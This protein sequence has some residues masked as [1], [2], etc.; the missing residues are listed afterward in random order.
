MAD[1]KKL[2][3][4]K[5][6]RLEATSSCQLRCPS[7]PTA[8]GAIRPV[9]GKGY[10]KLGDFQKLLDE[11]PWISKIELSNYGEMFLNPDLLGIMEYA[12]RRNVI[13]T[14][15]NGVNLNTVKEDVLKGLVKYEFRSLTCSIDGASS[16]T[17][18]VYRVGGDFDKVLEHIKKI[19]HYK[20]K[21]GSKYPLLTWQFV[22]FGHNQHEI[23]IAR[24][25]ARDFN[26]KFRLK[27]TW[28]D[29]F[30]P[31]QDKD[32]VKKEIGL[33]VSS[34]DEYEQKY[35]VDYMRGICHQLWDMPQINW[36][37][38]ML[39]CCRNF[40]GDFGGNAF[41]DGFLSSLN[42]EKI[43]YARDMLL[44]KK[45]A[46]EDIPCTTCDLYLSM[47]KN[48]TW[49]TPEETRIPIRGM[50]LIYRYFGGRPLFIRLLSWLVLA[51]EFFD[52][53]VM[54]LRRL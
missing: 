29:D 54:K 33:N 20:K 43:N 4:P 45:V 30:S 42:N 25:L 28:D 8:S 11:S 6:I 40:W 46:R 18:K 34:R 1:R 2:V 47:K 14:A 52:S 26:M 38:K 31:L 23:P 12:H 51:K 19:N 48:N 16:E 44:G 32:F 7:C 50:T 36:D 35:G 53:C 15:D 13:L 27:L 9:L 24:K 41:K 37:G 49:I 21:Y 39:G 17:Y 5:S 3:K 10:L 22:V